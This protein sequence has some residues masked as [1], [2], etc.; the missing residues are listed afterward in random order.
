MRHPS[1]RQEDTMRRSLSIAA[2]GLM[3]LLSAPLSSHTAATTPYTLEGVLNGAPYK[4][5]VPDPWN[6]TLVVYEDGYREVANRPGEIE[7]R[8]ARLDPP[9]LEQY[10][11][12]QG[13]ATAPSA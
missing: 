7:D 9:D 8:A 1:R 2:L 11:L 3:G 6:G 5:N 10:L 13:Y 12:S 4:I